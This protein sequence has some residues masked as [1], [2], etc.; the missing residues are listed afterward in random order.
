MSYEVGGLTD[1]LGNKYESTRVAYHLIRLL[2]E[3]NLA[4]TLEPIGIREEGVDI[5]IEHPGGE[6]HFEQCKGSN[7]INEHWRI[8]DLHSQGILK[9]AFKQIVN[10]GCQFHLTSPLPFKQLTDLC[11]S[12]RNSNDIWRDFYEHQVS[13]SQD[14]KDLYDKICLYLQDKE[15][16]EIVNSDNIFLFLKNFHITIYREDYTT[17]EDLAHRADL[18]FI[19]PSKLVIPFLKSYNIEKDQLRR[20]ITTYTLREDIKANDIEFRLIPQD[21]RVLPKISLLTNTFE[22]SISPFLINQEFIERPELE[23]LNQLVIDSSVVL[24]AAN[25]GLGKSAMLLEFIKQQKVKGTLCLPIRLDRQKPTGSPESFGRHLGLPDS[26]ALCLS[27]ISKNQNSI[28]IL[29]QLDALRWSNAHSNDALDVCKSLVEQVIQLRKSGCNISVVI[30]CREFDL[31]D[32]PQIKVWINGIDKNVKKIT[33]NPFGADIIKNTISKYEEFEGLSRFQQKT[34]SI[35]LWLSIYM[36]IAERNDTAPKFNNRLD[37]VNDFW[38]DR[39][40]L[41]DE[42]GLN[43]ELC[44]KLIN[45]IVDIMERM[46]ELS[47]PVRLLQ[48]TNDVSL[49]TLQSVDLLSIQNNQISFRHQSLFDYKV[50]QKMFDFAFDS[51]DNLIQYI[52]G[53]E[54]Q[55]LEKREHLKYALLM[56]LD[57]KPIKYYYCIESL[58]YSKD[59]RFHLKLLALQSLQHITQLTHPIEKLTFKLLNDI[60]WRNHFISN[61]VSNNSI[62]VEFLSAKEEL[63]KW[64]KAENNNHREQAIFLLRSVVISSPEIVVKNLSP[65]INLSKEWNEEINKA[66]PHKIEEDSFSIFQVR[67]QLLSLGVSPNYYWWKELS[68]NKPMFVLELIELLLYQFQDELTKEEHRRINKS[69]IS[70]NLDLHEFNEVYCISKKLHNNIIDILLPI[71]ENFSSKQK[72]YWAKIIWLDKH[73]SYEVEEKLA[74]GVVNLIIL[75]GKELAINPI[76]LHSKISPYLQSKS[77]VVIHIVANFLYQLPITYA[78]TIIQWLLDDSI[79]RFSCGNEHSEKRWNLAGRIIEKF[80]PHCSEVVL[81]KLINAIYFYKELD[82]KEHLKWILNQNR[83]RSEPHQ[84]ISYW[85]EAQHYLLPRLHNINS[86]SREND[87]LNMLFRKWGCP[88]FDIDDKNDTSVAGFTCSPIDSPNSLSFNA[89]R[90]LILSTKNL[91]NNHHWGRRKGKG[92]TQSSPTYFAQSLGMAA[93]NRPE[94]FALFSLSLPKVICKSYAEALIENIAETDINK[95]SEEYKV[96]WKACQTALI[97]EVVEHFEI[98]LSELEL[99][100]QLLMKVEKNLYIESDIVQLTELSINT[101]TLDNV[102]T[103]LGEDVD[104]QSLRNQSFNSS[105]GVSCLAISKLCWKDEV[106]A[107]KLRSTLEIIMRDSHPAIRIMAIDILCPFL[108]YDRQFA[109]KSFIKLVK[110]DIRL[111]GAYNGY[112]FFNLGF[113]NNQHEFTNVINQMVESSFEKI[114][115]KGGIQVIARWV[116]HDVMKEKVD[117]ILAG[118]INHRVGAAKVTKELICNTKYSSPKLLPIYEQLLNDPD[119]KVRMIVSGTLRDV[120]FLKLEI[121][122]ELIAIYVKSKASLDSSRNLFYMFGKL[123]SSLIPYGK[124]LLQLINNIV[125]EKDSKCYETRSDIEHHFPDTILKLYSEAVELEDNDTTKLCLDIWDKFFEAGIY[126]AKRV[127]DNLVPSL[128][129]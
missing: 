110:D 45:D 21:S 40:S 97:K 100:R 116:F 87:L 94:L 25:A 35:P 5:I 112:Q 64:L 80:S 43:S 82:D 79:N 70:V 6:E 128:L 26:P 23:E 86:I 62:F 15:T 95:I 39:F 56:L 32:D 61:V 24:L 52:G 107:N 117:F 68:V 46:G 115:E 73:R 108:D 51:P 29:D 124:Y 60:N 105:K 10:Q 7:G 90:K 22:N 18:L 34:L 38:K 53:F 114:R 83:K 101:K 129:N 33:L 28:L 67:K 98:K 69:N 57:T 120:N 30:V 54:K 102:E 72:E 89:W 103:V 76:K 81:S 47:I 58:L 13:K 123:D 41:I 126:D 49:R 1:K 42:Q 63:T 74:V 99:S 31:K 14:R 3:N 91:D 106:T 11:V 85:G 113:Y 121:R 55:T 27:Q 77:I 96:S 4:V 92:H 17:E 8:S 122:D 66:L 118:D 44:E 9:K 78:D 75:S 50:G 65:F 12:A 48:H 36:S 19:T 2:E 109:I 20:K 16:S 59:I 125:L 88:N 119:K 84:I 104:Y 37:L 111:V 127:T 71:V 93:Q